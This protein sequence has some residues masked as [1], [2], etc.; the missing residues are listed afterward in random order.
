LLAISISLALP[1]DSVLGQIR[2]KP[3]L[4][5]AVKERRETIQ[6]QQLVDEGAQFLKEGNPRLAAEKFRRALQLDPD[7][8]RAQAYVAQ[9]ALSE[10]HPEVAKHHA[11]E[12][13]KDNPK[14]ARAHFVLGQILMQEGRSLAAFDH[15]RKAADAVPDEQDHTEAKRLLGRLRET[16]PQ[17]FGT[18]RPAAIPIPPPAEPK[19]TSPQPS[20]IRPNLAVFTFDEANPQ[21]QG[22]GESMA[23][24]LTT[25]LINSGHYRMIERKQ[26]F[27]VLEEQ[28][29]GQSGALDSE[30]AVAVGKIMGLDAIV[31]GSISPLASVLEADARILHVETG[32]AVAAAHSRG[33]SPDQLRQM[34][35]TLAQ[36]LAGH[37]GMIPTRAPVDTT[38]EVPK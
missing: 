11:I 28:A 2:P 1:C 6:A 30:T 22:W 36:S 23:E 26:L 7:N 12:A 5:Q 19:T 17:W 3:R 27:K 15:L 8:D 33:A 31:V 9:I 14:N 16:H 34:A 24:M 10:H 20:G 21:P 37:A 29:L 18:S 25:A 4:K 13:L 38:S 32:E 35:E